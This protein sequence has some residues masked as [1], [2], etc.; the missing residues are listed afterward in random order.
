MTNNSQKDDGE[1]VERRKGPADRRVTDD[2]R[3]SDRIVEDK[4]PRRQKP[5]RRQS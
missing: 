2:R 5:D 4:N 3:D 1:R